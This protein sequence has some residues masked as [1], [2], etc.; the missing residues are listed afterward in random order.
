LNT[1]SGKGN[2]KDCCVQWYTG[3]LFTCHH[4]KPASI[5]FIMKVKSLIL[6]AILFPAVAF[7]QNFTI[8]GTIQD[9]TS[10]ESLIGAIGFF[11]SMNLSEPVL[12][13]YPE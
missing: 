4:H 2:G 1:L 7:S 13:I 5:H 10:G 3:F 8:S 9:G 12:F 11:G 6:A